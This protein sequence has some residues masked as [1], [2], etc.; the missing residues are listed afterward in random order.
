M[1][2]WSVIVK[3]RLRSGSHMG[4]TGVGEGPEDRCAWTTLTQPRGLTYPTHAGYLFRRKRRNGLPCILPEAVALRFPR[5]CEIDTNDSDR[6]LH[7]IV[8]QVSW[9]IN[10]ARKGLLKVAPA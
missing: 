4:V 2:D 6:T 5:S 9:R 3:L 1:T 8:L 7:A 10:D